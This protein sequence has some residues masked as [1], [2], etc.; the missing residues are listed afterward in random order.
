MMFFS[1]YIGA[2]PTITGPAAKVVAMPAPR[3]S[4]AAVAATRTNLEKG[5]LHLRLP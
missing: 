4:A 5:D 1:A 3:P 2:P